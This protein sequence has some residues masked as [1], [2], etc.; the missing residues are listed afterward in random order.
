ME[1]RKEFAKESPTIVAQGAS[2][3]VHP[4]SGA[5]RRAINNVYTNKLAEGISEIV[6][7]LPLNERTVDINSF[8]NNNIRQ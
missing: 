4:L 7:T 8:A 5:D 6:P 2:A 1:K 3:A